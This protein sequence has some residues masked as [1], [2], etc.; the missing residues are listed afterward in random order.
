MGKAEAARG[1]FGMLSRH[2]EKRSDEQSSRSECADGLLRGAC[3]GR[4]SS[5][6]FSLAMTRKKHSPNAGTPLSS[7]IALRVA[8]LEFRGWDA[9]VCDNLWEVRASNA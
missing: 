6:P 3:H 9:M 4:A 1:G 2:C 5:G 8:C 7:K